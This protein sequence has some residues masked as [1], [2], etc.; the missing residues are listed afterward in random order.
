M[1][2]AVVDCFFLEFVIISQWS[3]KIARI[4]HYDGPS[5]VKWSQVAPVTPY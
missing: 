1:P 2:I 3:N 4:D 5:T